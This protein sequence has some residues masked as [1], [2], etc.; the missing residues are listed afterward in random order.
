MSRLDLVVEASGCGTVDEKDVMAGLLGDRA[1][2]DCVCF[3]VSRVSFPWLPAMKHGDRP[4]RCC[5]L[6]MLGSGA[7]EAQWEKGGVKPFAHRRP[8][9]MRLRLDESG[10]S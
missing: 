10:E 6:G 3:R 8:V 9:R 1:T 5:W 2:Q 7:W 4:R